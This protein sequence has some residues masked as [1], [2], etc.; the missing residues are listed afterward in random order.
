M[1]QFIIVSVRSKRMIDRFNFNASSKHE[2]VTYCQKREGIL[3]FHKLYT[4]ELCKNMIDYKI[5]TVCETFVRI[6][7]FFL[8]RTTIP[9]NLA[10]TFLPTFI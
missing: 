8:F 9:C 1:V 3:L 2:S 4:Y 7:Y 5:Y 6:I 10:A